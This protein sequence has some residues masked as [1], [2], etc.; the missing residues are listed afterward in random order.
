MAIERLIL[1]ALPGIEPDGRWQYQVSVNAKGE[2]LPPVDPDEEAE[3]KVLKLWRGDEGRND[4]PKSIEVEIFCN[5]SSYKT[6][7]LS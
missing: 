2:V 4:R 5:G 1:I 3:L 6:V 7:I